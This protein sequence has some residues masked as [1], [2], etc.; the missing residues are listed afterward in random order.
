MTFLCTH[1]LFSSLTVVNIMLMT[2]LNNY[3]WYK[4]IILRIIQKSKP[5]QASKQPTNQTKHFP[6]RAWLL[7]FFKLLISEKITK[8]ISKRYSNKYITKCMYF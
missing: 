4:D 7:F 2:F 3:K 8:Y 1:S 5:N 6:E